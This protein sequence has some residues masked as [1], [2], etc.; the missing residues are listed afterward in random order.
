MF[1]SHLEFFIKVFICEMCVKVE[2]CS[3]YLIEVS[4]PTSRSTDS[5]Q[6]P[7]SAPACLVTFNLLP[8]FLPHFLPFF[9]PTTQRGLKPKK[10]AHVSLTS[11]NRGDVVVMSVV[12][13]VT[14]ALNCLASAWQPGLSAHFLTPPPPPPSLPQLTA[15]PI[16]VLLPIYDVNVRE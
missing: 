1:C 12:T 5:P 14:V 7:P 9:P 16:W 4:D 15:P 2:K 10:V 11:S 6:S 13:M 3:V 8:S